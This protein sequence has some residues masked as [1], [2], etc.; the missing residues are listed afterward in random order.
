MI[1]EVE[2]TKFISYTLTNI[3]VSS[4]NSLSLSGIT[5]SFLLQKIIE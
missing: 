1:F 3:S 2:C 5:Y 4:T